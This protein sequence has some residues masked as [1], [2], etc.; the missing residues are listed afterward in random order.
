MLYKI[1]SWVIGTAVVSDINVATKSE[2]VDSVGE[3]VDIRIF[4]I[5]VAFSN[6]VTNHIVFE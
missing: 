4:N 3:K 1:K 2:I 6:Y 5:P